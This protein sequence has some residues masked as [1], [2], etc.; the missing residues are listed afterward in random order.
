MH[1][2]LKI[3]IFDGKNVEQSGALTQINKCLNK[4]G[5]VDSLIKWL[6]DDDDN[7]INFYFRSDEADGNYIDLD[8]LDCLR[9]YGV[10]DLAD[11]I[12][13]LMKSQEVRVYYS[14]GYLR[15]NLVITPISEMSIA[16]TWS[17]PGRISIMSLKMNMDL[18]RDSVM[19]DSKG[20]GDVFAQ[21]LNE[22]LEESKVAP[23]T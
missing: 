19:T 15:G 6:V 13:D 8:D 22:H 4:Q 14:R 1:N 21:Q 20:Q 11:D 12:N 23:C 2:E 16:P 18:M 3:E 9:N 17:P 7:T 5:L 10:A